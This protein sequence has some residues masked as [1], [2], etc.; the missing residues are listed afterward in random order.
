MDELEFSARV[1]GRSTSMSA[2]EILQ[3]EMKRSSFEWLSLEQI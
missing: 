2:I 1:N 3:V